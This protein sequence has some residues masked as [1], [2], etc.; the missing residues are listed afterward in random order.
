M[1]ILRT[2]DWIAEKARRV[3]KA[4]V[5]AA[6]EAPAKKCRLRIVSRMSFLARST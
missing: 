2:C 4:E 3:E 1:P 5:T 6:A